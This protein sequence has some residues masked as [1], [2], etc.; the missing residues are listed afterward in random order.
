M[1]SGGVTMSN[2]LGEKIK[3]AR[4]EKKLTQKALGELIDKSY[5]AI[6]KYENGERQPP[7]SVVKQLSEVLD[8]PMSNFVSDNYKPSI[9]DESR[10]K[11]RTIFGSLVQLLD[12]F[13]YKI[14][15][16]ST[17]GCSF[18][19]EEHA[20]EEAE[21]FLNDKSN[22]IMKLINSENKAIPVSI[23]DWENIEHNL[24]NFI[25]FELFKLKN[26]RDE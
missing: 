10:K 15:Y 24:E 6:R 17:G 25:K 9:F 21:R 14:E 13:G 7:L 19:S 2:N 23:S 16:Q 8:V 20:E 11:D 5:E 26:K 12:T 22:I 1:H 4:K 3:L 18:I